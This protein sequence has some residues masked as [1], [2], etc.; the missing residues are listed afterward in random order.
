MRED[1]KQWIDEECVIDMWERTKAKD[2][3]ASF[4]AWKKKQNQWRP[5]VSEWGLL[6]RNVEGVTKIKSGGMIYKGI[7]LRAKEQQ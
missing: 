7:R 2:L 4:E 1:L 6:M 3:F 5:T